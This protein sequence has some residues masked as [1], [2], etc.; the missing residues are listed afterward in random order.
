MNRSSEAS[1][2]ILAPTLAAVCDRGGLILSG[3]FRFQPDIRCQR[4][5]GGRLPAGYEP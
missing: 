2:K 5:H 3:V 1:R 4:N